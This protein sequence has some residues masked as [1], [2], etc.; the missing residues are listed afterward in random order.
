MTTQT[1]LPEDPFWPRA[2]AWLAGTHAD[3]TLGKLAVLGA[4]LRLGSITPG[5]CDLAPAA[6]RAILRKF[7][8]YDIEANTD[9]HL[10]EARDLGDLP[11]SDSTLE[12]AFEPLSKS[13]RSALDEA[14]A[15]IIIGGDNGV[16]RPG[17]HGVTDSLDQCGLVTI[18]AHLDLR[19]LA[20]GL[21]NG[22]PVR[23]L[24]ADGM[25]GKNIVQ[26]G[27]QPFANSRVY[28]E[29]ASEVGITVVTMDQIRAH[30]VETLLNESLDYLTS[31]VETIYV[32]L[33]I[34]V[35]DRIF[36][37]ATPGSRPGGLS[38]WELRRV[39]WL[40]G[41]RPQVRAMDLVEVDPTQDIADATM[42]TTGACLLSFASGL[43]TRL[44]ASS[45]ILR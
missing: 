45:E 36:A 2:S 13:V 15:V 18:D 37:P 26:L 5:R 42:L 27:I 8:C 35:L 19:D 9:L 1:H 12:D 29:V 40:C 43:L 3:D 28:A 30:G 32:D 25:P 17:A 6:V 41:V 16:T 34:D 22:N 7:S 23:A 44:A 10:L 4:P 24:L 39:A 20:N 31:F 33:D 21:T 14:H 38:P 11:L